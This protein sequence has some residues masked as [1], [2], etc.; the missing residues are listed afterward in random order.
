MRQILVNH[1]RDR[2][3]LK[4]RGRD[5]ARRV[6]LSGVAAPTKGDPDI[7]A[8]HEAL[9]ELAGL[10]P[11]QARIAE[12][13]FFGGLTNPEVAEALG[14]SLRTVELD[15]TMAK[16]WLARRLDGAGSEQQ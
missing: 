12:M 8:V 14:V 1:A 6:T 10:A 4:R 11:R 7:L 2:A 9:L 13:R 3:A 5:A 15:W 16:C